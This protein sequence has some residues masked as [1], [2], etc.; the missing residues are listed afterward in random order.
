MDS[1]FLPSQQTLQ[2]P[3]QHESRTYFPT[4]LALLIPFEK[5]ISDS[6]TYLNPTQRTASAGMSNDPAVVNGIILT[7][8]GKQRSGV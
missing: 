3:P 4:E 2:A 1:Q 7:K 6:V 8:L 5:N